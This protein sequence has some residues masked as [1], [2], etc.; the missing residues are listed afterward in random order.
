MMSSGVKPDELVMPPVITELL[1]DVQLFFLNR[2][3]PHTLCFC[4]VR[5]LEYCMPYDNG[6]NA[7]ETSNAGLNQASLFY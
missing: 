1:D 6:S 4:S 5:S 2:T 7:R 3:L